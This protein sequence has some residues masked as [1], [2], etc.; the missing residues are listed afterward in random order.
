ME[1]KGRVR[2]MLV[3]L[4][5]VAGACGGGSSE[6]SG[7]SGSPDDESLPA[8]EQAFKDAGEVS[9]MQDTHEDLFPAYSACMSLE[10]WEA[11]DEK[12]PDA[13]DGVEPRLYAQ[14]VCSNNQEAIG[15]TP[16]CEAALE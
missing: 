15:D 5:L 6:D 11:A 7:D 2:L 3:A 8:C 4:A 9:D 14:N 16:I 12:Y 10:E 13:I 1:G